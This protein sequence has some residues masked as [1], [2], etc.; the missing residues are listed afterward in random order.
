MKAKR[1]AVVSLLIVNL[2]LGSWLTLLL[3]DASSAPEAAAPAPETVI[4]AVT[5]FSVADVAAVMIKNANASYAIMQSGTQLE[6]LTAVPGS[7]DSSQMRALVYASSTITSSRKIEDES[8][9]AQ[10]GFENPRAEVT[11]YLAD[12]TSEVLKVLEDNPL[13]ASCYLY[14]QAHNAVYLVSSDVTSL[15]LRSEQDF[16]SHTVFSL[17]SADDLQHLTRV[18]LFPRGGRTY[19]L[20]ST[21]QGYYITAPIRHRLAADQVYTNVYVN[22]V[23]LYAD[24]V[25]A[26]GVSLADYG[27]DKPDLEVEIRMGDATERAVFLLSD[28]NTALMAAKGGSTVYRLSD[29]PVLMLM[30]DYT[31]LL[32]GSIVSYGAGDIAEMTLASGEKSVALTFTGSSTELLVKQGDNVLDREFVSALLQAVNQIVPYAEL[33][34]VPA[35]EPVLSVTMMLRSGT[36]ERIELLDI[37]QGLYAVSINGEANFATG[38]E[39]LAAL[40]SILDTF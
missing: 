30:Q 4:H 15:F 6:M 11:I 10:Y 27:L 5:D 36:Q 24:E 37:G 13:D 2:L 16:L 23:T 9:F 39:S 34:S 33:S 7:Y 14:S 17:R 29:S 25:V 3:L 38:P 19:T 28:N 22:L 18:T 21:D 40:Q 31:A 1:I 26:S 20:S 8:A 12:G 32:G 35:L